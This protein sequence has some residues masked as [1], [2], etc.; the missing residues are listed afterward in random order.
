[1]AKRYMNQTLK[2]SYEWNEKEKKRSYNERVMQLE[3]GTFS[4]LVFAATGGLGRECEKVYNRI[5][6]IIAEKRDAPYNTIITWVRRKVGFATINSITTC[7]RGSRCINNQLTSSIE[8]DA[9]VSE[10]VAGY[11]INIIF[12]NIFATGSL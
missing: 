11:V 6:S 3:H 8:N 12:F 4:P 1:M 2:R 5:G 10:S 9:V 7:L